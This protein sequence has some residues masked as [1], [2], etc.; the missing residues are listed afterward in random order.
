MAVLLGAV[1]AD[2]EVIVVVFTDSVEVL[3]MADLARDN[4]LCALYVFFTKTASFAALY[5]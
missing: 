5:C 1:D 4:W 2:G 3:D